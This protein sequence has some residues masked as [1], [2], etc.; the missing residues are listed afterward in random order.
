MLQRRALN[1]WEKK[2]HASAFAQQRCTALTPQGRDSL[3]PTRSEVANR[4]CR[5]TAV[6]RAIAYAGQLITSPKGSQIAYSLGSFGVSRHTRREIESPQGSA[7]GS[8]QSVEAAQLI[9]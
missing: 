2:P 1:R 5:K 3:R 6:A 9:R 4:A 7:R 8:R